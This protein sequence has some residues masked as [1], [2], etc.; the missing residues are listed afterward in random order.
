MVQLLIRLMVWK[1]TSM[2]EDLPELEPAEESI[3]RSFVPFNRDDN[4]SRYL[5]LRCSGFTIREALNLIGDAKSTLSHWRKDSVFL[6]C[7]NSL[8]ELRKTLAL[9]YVGLETLRN[10]RLILEKD[11]RVAKASLEKHTRIVE[12]DG[13]QKEVNVGMDSQD[14]QYLLRMR[15]HYTPQQLQTLEQLLGNNG[16]NGDTPDAHW[17]DF[18]LDISRT[19]ETVKIGT[20]QRTEPVLN[21]I[22]EE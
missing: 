18:F 12:V 9:E 21:K 4:R 16:G 1:V 5:G 17:T 15:Q 13:E 6:E 11:F 14:F 19:T 2:T 3:P 10:Y 8:P 7:E 20:R 22:A